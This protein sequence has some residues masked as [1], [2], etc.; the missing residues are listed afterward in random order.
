MILNMQRHSKLM[1]CFYIIAK[2][3]DLEVSRGAWFS[4]FPIDRVQLPQWGKRFLSSLP[5]TSRKDDNFKAGDS[6]ARFIPQIYL[7]LFDE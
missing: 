6:P 7:A 5:D 2:M 3:L 1:H 4:P